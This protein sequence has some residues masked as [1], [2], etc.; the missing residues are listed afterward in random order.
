M[1]SS[2]RQALVPETEAFL[3][4]YD[5]FSQIP[6]ADGL[7]KEKV[8]GG[9][10]CIVQAINGNEAKIPPMVK[11]L[12]CIDIDVSLCIQLASVGHENAEQAGLTSLRCL[13]S[14]AKGLQVSPNVPLDLD[15]ETSRSTFWTTGA[16]SAVQ[17]HVLDVI[18][19]IMKALTHSGEI[20]EAVCAVFRAGFAEKEANPFVFS[21]PVVV[22]F[23]VHAD[24]NTPRLGS[25]IS[26]ACSLISSRAMDPHNSDGNLLQ[27][28]L[29]WISG[30]LQT[31]SGESRV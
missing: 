16:G 21:T 15:Q 8:L 20:V 14:V 29:A 26:T 3:Q 1:C 28:Q 19:K 7:V 18:Y 17:L 13:T 11:L 6:G 25:V 4:E 24:F 12:G 31:L 22:N 2:C 5:R 30:L 23:I 27:S 10:A 9:I